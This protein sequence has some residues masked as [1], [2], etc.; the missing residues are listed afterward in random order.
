MIYVTEL[1]FSLLFSEKEIQYMWQQT[2]ED[3]TV[4]VQV[5][6]QA[7]ESDL[8]VTVENNHVKIKFKDSALLEGS[9]WH[10]LEPQLTTWTLNSGK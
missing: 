8:N 2:T 10:C 9:A 6:K 5:P 4:W 1:M 7:S 3:I